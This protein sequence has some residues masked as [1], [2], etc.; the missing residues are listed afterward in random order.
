MGV[1][2][3]VKVGSVSADDWRDKQDEEQRGQGEEEVFI[4]PSFVAEDNVRNFQYNEMFH[5]SNHSTPPPLF[6]YLYRFVFVFV[7]L[8]SF[9]TCRC[10]SPTK[11]QVLCLALVGHLR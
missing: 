1:G 6:F 7:N 9:H 3:I 5:F 8:H 11:A 4:R 2:G 10:F